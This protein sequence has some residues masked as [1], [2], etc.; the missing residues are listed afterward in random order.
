MLFFFKLESYRQ[1]SANGVP[2]LLSAK[3]ALVSAEPSPDNPFVMA[4]PGAGRG[5]QR[6]KTWQPPWICAALST[7]L[8]FSRSVQLSIIAFLTACVE[9][10]NV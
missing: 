2:S 6:V 3:V 7:G 4:L 1:R 8:Y 10:V 5:P 9:N